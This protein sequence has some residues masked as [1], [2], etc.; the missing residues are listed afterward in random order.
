MNQTAS[1]FPSSKT[2]PAEMNKKDFVSNQT[3][4]WC[5]G[6]GDYAI[7]A[8]VQKLMPELGIPRENIVF[9]S[10]IGCSSRFPYYMNTYGM[11]TIHGRAPAFA[12]G[13]KVARP[14]LS[15]WIVTGDGDGLGIGGNHMLHML[16]RNL[17]VNILLF[18]NRIYGLTKGQ[19]SPTSEQGLV[20]KSTPFGSLEPQLNPMAFALSAGG[21]FIA[22][23]LDVDAKA[24]QVTLKEAAEHKGTSFV[25]IY[26]NCPIFND[27]TF[28]EISER[29][30]RE[31]RI[32]RLQDGQPFLFGKEQNK[33]IRLN[34]L[35]PKI[36]DVNENTDLSEIIVHDQKSEDTIMAH[37]L[38][39]MNH[40]N[41]PVP[42]GVF[43]QVEY[44]RFEESVDEQIQNQIEKKG[45]GD[46]R[47]L[48]RGTQVWEA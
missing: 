23:A 25:E 4:R 36:V 46:L 7:L 47:K 38:T 21:S 22:R 35:K 26:Q 34:G 40:P 39:G 43:R 44:S 9:I 48:I 45:K 27:G 17:D 19:V 20:T 13:L 8:S 15:V 42:M 11:H 2:L 28:S 32:L 16:R 1:I 5:P 31:D 33:G 10:G 29:S 6:C 30:L 24:L 14:E 12:T 18:N 37:L 41:F 3:V